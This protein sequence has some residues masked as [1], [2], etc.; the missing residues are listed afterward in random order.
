MSEYLE[1]S[2][3]VL[4]LFRL[5]RFVKAPLWCLLHT[6]LGVSVHETNVM[7]TVGPFIPNVPD[8]KVALLFRGLWSLQLW[9]GGVG[10][11]T[12]TDD[13]LDLALCNLHI[14]GDSCANVWT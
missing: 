12:L 13:L 4:L 7:N 5:H 6:R 11:W 10:V 1:A 3:Q 2:L 14:W 9:W 8:W